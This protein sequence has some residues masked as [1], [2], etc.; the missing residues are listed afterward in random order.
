MLLSLD[1]GPP[2]ARPEEIEE[3]DGRRPQHRLSFVVAKDAIDGRV[4]DR[5]IH[6][7]E[8]KGRAPLAGLGP[9]CPGSA[10]IP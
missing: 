5:L 1:L 10:S 2:R 9:D 3:E 4:G 8:D 7:S 6:A